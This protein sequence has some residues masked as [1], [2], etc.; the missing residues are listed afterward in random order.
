MIRRAN[1]PFYRSPKAAPARPVGLTDAQLRMVMVAAC[2]LPEKR[3]TLL[4]RVA[5]KL[6]LHGPAFTDR[7]VGEAITSALIGLIHEPAA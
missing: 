5:A 7:D 4:E 6:D 3:V 1:P 2:P